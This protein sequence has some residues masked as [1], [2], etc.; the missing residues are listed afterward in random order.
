MTIKN[1]TALDIAITA[2]ADLAFAL[3]DKLDG[4]AL[5]PAAHGARLLLQNEG[6]DF[7]KVRSDMNDAMG[8]IEG[9]LDN[10]AAPEVAAPAPTPEV[11]APA[12]TPEVA[13]PVTGV[14]AATVAAL[15]REQVAALIKAELTSMDLVK[16]ARESALAAFEA[17]DLDYE[18]IITN[19]VDLD[20]IARTAMDEAIDNNVSFDDLARDLL[21]EKVDNDLSI[22]FDEEARDILNVKIDNNLSIDFDEEARDI[23][24]D[25]VDEDFDVEAVT[26]Q[27]I[28]ALLKSKPLTIT[29]KD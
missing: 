6:L 25:K 7:A 28:R 16:V 10:L 18:G 4:D 14:D 9:V 24:K 23:V 12:P 26:E 11:A 3:L 17:A 20:D 8:R 22:D 27:V 5:T 13:A 2:F 19:N 29:F 1:N 15:V 21:S